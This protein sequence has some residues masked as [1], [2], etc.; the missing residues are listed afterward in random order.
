MKLKHI[1]AVLVASSVFASSPFAAPLPAGKPA[2][3]EEAA[4]LGTS[5]LLWIGLAAVIAGI[6]VAASNNSDGI[7][8]PTAGTGA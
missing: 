7:M 3:T 8:T 4:F 5:S 1:A 6:A 2:G